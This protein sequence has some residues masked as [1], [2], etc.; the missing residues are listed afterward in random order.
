MELRNVERFSSKADIYKKFRP[1]YPKELI[2][3]LYSQVG[4]SHDS[5]IADIGSGTGIFSRLLLEKGSHV[6]CV[7][8]NADM[9]TIAENEL[10]VF[11][12]F[13]SISAPAE[14]TGLQTKSI[15]FITVATAFHWFD[16]QLFKSECRR[17]LVN[18]GTVVLV[19]NMRD[20]KSE[21]VLKEHEIRMKYLIG[22]K[23][24]R[25]N[26]GE[27]EDCLNF[28][29]DNIYEC[30]S[31]RND[32]SLDRDIYIGWNMSSSFAPSEEKDPDK[33]HALKHDLN[34]LYDE[35]CADGMLIYPHV[36]KCYT[37]KV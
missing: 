36:T 30:N 37:G 1:S 13:S 8:P 4:F 35:Y 5:E 2:N 18:N 32:L 27:S 24:E 12:G 25:I 28:F 6:Y 29:A 26:S 20:D 17:I 11:S 31:F 19:W 14:N 15:D 21:I 22:R 23:S 10:N 9:R 3:Y 33:H 34:V 7:E 16:R